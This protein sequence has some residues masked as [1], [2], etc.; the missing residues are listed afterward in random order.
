[1]GVGEPVFIFQT[2]YPHLI[3][4]PKKISPIAWQHINLH[5]RYEFLNQLDPVSVDAI[6]Q[7]L[8]KL[9]I[10]RKA[11]ALSAFAACGDF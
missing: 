5:G 4:S 3:V 6:I 10:H 2:V 9:L 11:L 7:E 1:M 8:T